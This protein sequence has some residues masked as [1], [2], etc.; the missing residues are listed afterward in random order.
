MNDSLCKW[1]GQHIVETCS[2]VLCIRAQSLGFCCPGCHNAYQQEQ[3]KDLAANMI[4]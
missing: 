1:C 2:D 3:L 4:K